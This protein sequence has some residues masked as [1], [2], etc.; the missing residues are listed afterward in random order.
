MTSPLDPLLHQPVR[1]RLAAFLAARGEATFT[2]LRQALEVTDGNLEAHLKKLT[3]AGYVDTRK[4]RSRG[5]PQTLYSLSEQG[6]AAFVGYVE[7]LHAL[8]PEP[9]D[10]A[11]PSSDAL[12]NL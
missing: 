7:T 6:H 1:T 8:L 4:A 2:E 9:D 11:A 3:G 10:D 5:R 12:P